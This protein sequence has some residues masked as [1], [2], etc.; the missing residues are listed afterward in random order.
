VADFRDE[1]V[2]RQH[3]NDNWSCDPKYAGPG[4]P[5]SSSAH[6]V[7]EVPEEV[8]GEQRRGYQ[9]WHRAGMT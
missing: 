2:R 9:E 3:E 7:V 1:S 4:H 8:Y 6:G 5:T